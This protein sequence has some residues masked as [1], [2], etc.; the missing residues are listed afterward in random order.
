MACRS[1]HK[2]E[3]KMNISNNRHDKAVS[4]RLFSGPFLLSASDNLALGKPSKQI[5]IWGDMEKWNAD[6]GNNGDPNSDIYQDHCFHTD[7][8]TSPWWEVDLQDVYEIIQVNITNRADCCGK[9]L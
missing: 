1:L 5:S 2:Y 8:N 3:K 4:I 7:Q 9:W 6:K